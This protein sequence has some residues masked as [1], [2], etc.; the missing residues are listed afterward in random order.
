LLVNVSHSTPAQARI[1]Q[2]AIL[3]STTAHPA[4]RIVNLV[5]F[6]RLGRASLGFGF[7]F[8]IEMRPAVV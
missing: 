2:R 7:S 8:R 6:N 4:Y 3:D 5:N 1:N